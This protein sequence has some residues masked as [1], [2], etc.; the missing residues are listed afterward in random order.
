MPVS[1]DR[2][3]NWAT[4]V[5]CG[6]VAVL[7]LVKSYTGYHGPLPLTSA[8]RG[9]EVYAVGEHFKGVDGIQ[10]DA[11]STTVLMA[12]RSNRHF[13]TASMPF[14]QKILGQPR[15][16][17]RYVVGLPQD[18]IEGGQAYLAEH[19]IHV[20]GVVR[21]SMIDTLPK[22]H[23]TPTVIVLDRTSRILGLWTG[24]LDAAQEQDCVRLLDDVAPRIT[25]TIARR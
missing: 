11:A 5:L 25:A 16:D 21:Y 9:A 17:I 8:K 15:R 22:I 1:S 10:L 6:V 24:Q 7:L 20:D 12:L 4:I 18:T 3:A 2:L 13:C 23:G 14:Y 19:R